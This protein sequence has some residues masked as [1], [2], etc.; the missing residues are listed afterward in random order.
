MVYFG[1]KLWVLCG[2][3][4]ASEYRSNIFVRIEDTQI[5]VDQVAA[6]HLLLFS[7]SVAAETDRG[8]CIA[9][10]ACTTWIDRHELCVHYIQLPSNN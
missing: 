2:A 6:S 3:V 9:I 4:E 8:L 7:L 1:N 5:I 10:V